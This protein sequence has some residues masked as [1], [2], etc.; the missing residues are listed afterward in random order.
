MLGEALESKATALRPLGNTTPPS[1]WPIPIVRHK[2]RFIKAR[3]PL[4]ARLRVVSSFAPQPTSVIRPTKKIGCL[5]SPALFLK[6]RNAVPPP[7]S[8]DC[9]KNRHSSRTRQSAKNKS[10]SF[11]D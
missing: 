9:F 5:H 11:Q 1:P 8:A 6:V 10:A 7:Q 4:A 3:E 2:R